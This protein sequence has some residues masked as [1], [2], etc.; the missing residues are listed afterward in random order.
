MEQPGTK[1]DPP[2]HEE[3]DPYGVLAVFATHYGIALNH[4]NPLQAFEGAQHATRAY[5]NSYDFV[6][7]SGRDA[8]VPS[9]KMVRKRVGGSSK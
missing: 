1:F 5:L 4:S 2:D 6:D 9:Y 3:R 8:Q 7:L